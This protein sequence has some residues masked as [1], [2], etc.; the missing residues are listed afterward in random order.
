MIHHHLSP[1]KRQRIAPL[2]CVYPDV[3]FSFDL[4]SLIF[5]FYTVDE[6]FSKLILVCPTFLEY[7]VSYD[8]SMMLT[9]KIVSYDYGSIWGSNK[10]PNHIFDDK[11]ENPY[12]LVQVIYKKKKK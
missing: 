2:S 9:K 5:S 6:I 3:L 10:Y 1:S 7:F 4:L 8:K 12:K 11:Y